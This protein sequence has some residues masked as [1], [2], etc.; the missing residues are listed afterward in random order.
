VVV[1][2]FA[3]Y[4][5]VSGGPSILEWIYPN[6]LFP[7]AVRASAV[8]IVVGISRIGAAAGTYLLPIGIS[9]IGLSATLP[10]G[11]LVTVVALV[12]TLAWAPETKGRSLSET[13]SLTPAGPAVLRTLAR[14]SRP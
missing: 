10:I 1:A 13:S 9:Q 3:F 6:E 12:V 8:G 7:T 4:A 2:A 14:E 11:A 5:L